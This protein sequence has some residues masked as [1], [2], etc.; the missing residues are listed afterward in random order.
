[1]SVSVHPNGPIR[2]MPIIQRGLALHV[3]DCPIRAREWRG[4]HYANVMDDCTGCP[5]Q[6]GITFGLQEDESDDELHGTKDE[7]WE[8]LDGGHVVCGG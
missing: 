3:D 8:R 2:A 5:Y 1:M 7:P 6:Q 4:K